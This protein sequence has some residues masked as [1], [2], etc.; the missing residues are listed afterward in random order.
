VSDYMACQVLRQ[1]ELRFLSL[2]GRRSLYDQYHRAPPGHLSMTESLALPPKPKGG[3]M[4]NFSVFNFREWLV[5][6]V[7]IPIFLV[8]LAAAA[9]VVQW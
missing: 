5:P 6:P 2:F 3:H 8:L 4:P 9:M 7:S 1:N